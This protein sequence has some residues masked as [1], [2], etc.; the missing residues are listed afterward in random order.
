MGWDCTFHL[1]DPVAITA[2]M[3]SLVAG[4]PSPASLLVAYP[5]QGA[6]LWAEAGRRVLEDSVEDACQIAIYVASASLP[7]HYERGVA[8]SFGYDPSPPRRSGCRIPDSYTASPETMLGPLVARRPEL[9]GHF[10]TCFESN[11]DTGVYIPPGWTVFAAQAVR[12]HLQGLD[13]NERKRF[14]GLLRVLE[15]ATRHGLGFWEAT[16]LGVTQTNEAL[17]VPP[18]PKPK[19]KAEPPPPSRLDAILATGA[20]GPALV[21]AVLEGLAGDAADEELRTWLTSKGAK[22]VRSVEGL[23]L[24][25]RVLGGSNVLHRRAVSSMLPRIY[26]PAKAK[27]RD[28]FLPVIVSILAD[29]DTV[30]RRHGLSTPLVPKHLDAQVFGAVKIA[31]EDPDAQL[32]LV[33]WIEVALVRKWNAKRESPPTAELGPLIEAL[34][35][36][37]HGRV[38][39]GIRRA[40][41]VCL[42]KLGELPL[43]ALAFAQLLA[44]AEDELRDEDLP[45]LVS[46]IRS[47]PAP[48]RS[49]VLTRVAAA[50]SSSIDGSLLSTLFAL[51]EKWG[52][53]DVAEVCRGFVDH[54][55]EGLRRRARDCL[56][57]EGGRERT[58][59]VRLL[60][61]LAPSLAAA[62][63]LDAALECVEIYEERLE[64][65]ARRSRRAKDVR[66]IVEERA[67]NPI[68]R[69]LATTCA[70][71]RGA[72]RGADADALERRHAACPR[73]AA[74]RSLN[75]GYA[76]LWIELR[77]RDEPARLAQA[78]IDYWGEERRACD[79][80][81]AWMV[82]AGHGQ[83]V[84]RELASGIERYSQR[85]GFSDLILG[86]GAKL[87][88]EGEPLLAVE[89]ARLGF[90]HER[91]PDFLYNESCALLTAGQVEEAAEVLG[92]AI[93]IDPKQAADARN[94]KTFVPYFEHPLFVKLLSEG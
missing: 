5:E 29:D 19:P 36:S 84:V 23:A 94:D 71:W 63:S 85:H 11:C 93:D 49:Q 38:R 33:E 42:R 47:L 83:L 46:H 68:D 56:R 16:D 10:R 86:L 80:E 66:L 48:M 89:V 92:R 53:E 82:G 65:L 57:K 35:R 44:H 13:G 24:V 54:E 59:T 20:K 45:L 9:S 62:E 26:K 28:E 76:G 31:A 4:E 43:R 67:S 87:E 79:R 15:A 34:L 2:A 90:A 88:D 30:V 55:D 70:R 81:L 7:H 41:G 27:L 39:E 77:L 69:A 75:S 32:A 21:E 18:K 91:D 1:V 22:P 8:F 74:S 37:S 50:P 58:T 6:S 72:D 60:E 52:S 40:L 51:Y 64:R 14:F 73:N 78:I 25:R 3:T 12:S 17:L 61:L